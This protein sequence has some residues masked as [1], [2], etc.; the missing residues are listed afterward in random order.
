MNNKLPSID[1]HLHFD[2]SLPIEF[3]KREADKKGIVLDK[4]IKSLLTVASDCKNLGEYLEKF[5][6]PLSFLQTIEGIE[7][8]MYSLCKELIKDNTIY[9]EIR[10]APQLHLQKG[11]TQE[12]VVEAAISGLQKS[13]LC[14]GLI[15]CCM[16]GDDNT[17]QN[18]ETVRVTKAFL[19][20]GVVA[21]DLAGNEIAYPTKGFAELF[22]TAKK[23]KVPFTLHA[24][25]ASGPE[26]VMRAIEFG[27]SRIGHGVRSLE[28]SEV[29][30]LLAKRGI[31]IEVC[32]T[33]NINTCVFEGI[34]SFPLR[35][36]MD[37]GILVTVNSDNRTVSGT[38]ARRELEL[39]AEVFA[40]TKE[41]QQALL[42]NSAKAA[43]C[44][45][46]TKEKLVLQIKSI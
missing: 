3:V 27:A 15:L 16:R 28:S 41:E 5:D 45:E 39:L 7:S 6:F 38:T 26:S 10:F 24:G 1:L 12:E 13:E 46:K 33:S 19:G 37:S 4:D 31:P 44:D 21:C 34:D 9:A 43:F 18:L 2:G 29:T 30:T 36:L 35:R 14:G 23:L 17:I 25:E 20:K 40:L 8:G 32:P 11:L 22:E 42:I